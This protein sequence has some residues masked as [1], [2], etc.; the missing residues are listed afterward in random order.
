VGRN[1]HFKGDSLHVVSFHLQLTTDNNPFKYLEHMAVYI[2]AH[3]ILFCIHWFSCPWSMNYLPINIVL[4][5]YILLFLVVK[6]LQRKVTELC[7]K[8][9][10]LNKIMETLHILHK[11]LYWYDVGQPFA[12]STAAVLLGMDL[13]KFWTVSA[14]FYTILEEHFQVAL[15]MLE[16]GMCCAL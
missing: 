4:L 15:E 2:V 14:E 7:D 3:G 6:K 8:I 10:G 1:S 12:F 13:Y 9:Q 16:V 11:F 5:F